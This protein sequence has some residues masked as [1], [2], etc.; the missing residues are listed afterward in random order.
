[1]KTT[2]REDYAA[3]FAQHKFPDAYRFPF[4]WERDVKVPLAAVDK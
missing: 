3:L 4:T 1:M 2:T